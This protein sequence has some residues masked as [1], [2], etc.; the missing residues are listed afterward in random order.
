VSAS[1]SLKLLVFKF[2]K[3]DKSDKKKDALFMGNFA[4]E[5]EMRNH[6]SYD[7][8]KQVSVIE[9]SSRNHHDPNNK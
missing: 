5:D 8:F 3:G 6:T 7:E 4:Q 2:N 9:D 1:E